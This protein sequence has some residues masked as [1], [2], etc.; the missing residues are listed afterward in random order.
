MEH[1]EKIEAGATLKGKQDQQVEKPIALG[2]VAIMIVGFLL[3][4]YLVMQGLTLSF[5][6]SVLRHINTTTSVWQD[7][8]WQIITDLGGAVAVTLIVAITTAVVWCRHRVRAALQFAMSV[9]GAMA[10]SSI[11]KLIFSRER[12]ELWEQLITETTHSFPSGHAIASSAIALSVVVLLW[13]TKWR[14][15]AVAIGLVYVGLIGYSR[16]YLGVHYPTDVLAGWLV[17]IAWVSLMVVA[18]TRRRVY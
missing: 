16:L 2:V 11:L 14:I 15:W 1:N 18:F 8:M 7:T 12:P 10:L 5:D 17:S 6:A 9:V 13:Q 4:A 3:L